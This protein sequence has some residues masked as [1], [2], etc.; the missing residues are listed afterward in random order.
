MGEN[1]KATGGDGKEFADMIAKY[2][3]KIRENK[4]PST[5]TNKWFL[6]EIFV[7]VSNTHLLQSIHHFCTSLDMI[8]CMCRQCETNF[9]HG[10]WECPSRTPSEIRRW[11]CASKRYPGVWESDWSKEPGRAGPGSYEYFVTPR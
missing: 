4:V 2:A 5:L 6:H 11:K 7:Q 8:I 10:H 9:Y 1:Y 3:C